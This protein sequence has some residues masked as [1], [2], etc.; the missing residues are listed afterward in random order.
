M[1]IEWDE[2]KNQRNLE[3]HGLDFCDTETVFLGPIIEYEDTRRDYGEKRWIALGL[4]QNL[5]VVIVYTI[6]NNN[7]R[8]ISMRYANKRERGKYERQIRS[9]ALA[10]ITENR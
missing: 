4:L 7:L 9:K 1:L 5:M 10:D 8:I 3:R 2:S 6:R